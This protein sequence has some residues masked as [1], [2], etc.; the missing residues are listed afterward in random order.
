MFSVL[1]FAAACVALV[2]DLQGLSPIW[3]L[4]SW[5]VTR[6]ICL[7]EISLV[8]VYFNVGLWRLFIP[9]DHQSSLGA[10]AYICFQS[11]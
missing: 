7:S 2:S 1:C 8:A 5:F 9:Q 6:Q 10:G 4:L 3:L 11:M